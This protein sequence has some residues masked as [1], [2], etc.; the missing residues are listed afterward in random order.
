VL[1][2]LDWQQLLVWHQDL[3]ELRLTDY[4]EAL[5]VPQVLLQWVL[6][7]YLRMPQELQLQQSPAWCQSLSQRQHWL[8]QG[9]PHWRQMLLLLLPVAV[10]DLVLGWL[11]VQG[12]PVVLVHQVRAVGQ[13]CQSELGPQHLGFQ[14]C[15][16]LRFP[17]P[18]VLLRQLG[19]VKVQHQASCLSQTDAQRSL[20]APPW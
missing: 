18:Q 8:L 5:M 16:L 20:A 11:P 14:C 4:L 15:Q 7:A 9:W 13:C 12:C 10:V 6:P 3:V 17:L 1:P 19:L 2:C